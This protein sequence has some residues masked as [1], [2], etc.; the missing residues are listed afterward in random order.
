MNTILLIVSAI[1]VSSNGKRLP[2]YIKPCRK[3]DPNLNKC[4][5]EHAI[6]A[7]PAILKGDK[8]LGNPPL[9]PLHL[10]SIE[11]KPSE[12]L[13]IKLID[14]KLM[15]LE[16]IK[17]YDVSIDLKHRHVMTKQSFKRINLEGQYSIDGK[18]LLLN[19]H[20][21]GPANL[22]FDNV[23]VTYGVYYKLIT[24]KDGKQYIDQ[25]LT[26][27]VEYSLGKSHYQFDNLFNGNPEIGEQ[28]NKFLNENGSDIGK[29]LGGTVSETI[30]AIVTKI[31]QFIFTNLPYTEVFP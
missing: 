24:K 21:S 17:L 26:S 30:G 15:G 8:S 22:T 5:K 19:L 27:N 6:Q 2:S 16:T 14:I 9:V 25:N 31:L 18:L 11:I 20:G 23:D 10:D 1:L 4:A 12:K 29:E 3:D 13:T 7:I 28:L